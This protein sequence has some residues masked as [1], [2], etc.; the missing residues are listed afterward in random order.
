MQDFHDDDILKN[1]H[2]CMDQEN[3]VRGGPTLTIFLVDERIID[4]PANRHLT[5]FRWRVDGGPTLNTGLVAL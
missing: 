3:F 1:Q 2:A 5:A 4:P